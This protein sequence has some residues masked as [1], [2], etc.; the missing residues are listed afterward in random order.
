[1]SRQGKYSE[2]LGF[3]AYTVQYLESRGEGQREKEGREQRVGLLVKGCGS[4]TGRDEK[5]GGRGRKKTGM[6]DR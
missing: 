3:F 4:Q 6:E 5:G 1:M 2:S